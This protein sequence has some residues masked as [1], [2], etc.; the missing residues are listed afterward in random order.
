[1]I[2]C[3]SAHEI[4]WMRQSGKIVADVLDMLRE[5]VKPGITPNQ[6]NKAAEE[7]LTK[8]GAVPSFKGYCGYPATLCV[9]PNEVVVHGIPN[10]I[11]FQEGDIVSVDMGAVVHG[12]HTDAAR[13]YAVGSISKEK[14]DL[15]RVTEE[16]FFQGL[17]FCRTGNRLSDISSCI[18]QY[19]EG[20]GYSVVRVLT[21]HGVGRNLHEDPE[22]PNFGRPGRGPRLQ[23]G[24]TLAIEPMINLGGYAVETSA[25]GWTVS[26]CDGKPSA[27]YENTVAIVN[28]EP[29]ILTLN[30]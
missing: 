1:M 15:V 11:P 6:L 28:G 20:H 24:M 30:R 26:T 22:I 2:I 27:H 23:E 29:E 13:T 5:M 7:Y 10:D 21:G 8:C 9:S 3:K 17:R 25:D 14:A 19:C 16:S 4:E 12:F 18:Q